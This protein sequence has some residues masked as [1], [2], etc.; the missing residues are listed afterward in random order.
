MLEYEVTAVFLAKYSQV[1]NS[2]SSSKTDQ[3]SPMA[4]VFPPDFPHLWS[5]GQGPLGALGVVGTNS[6]PC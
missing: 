6:C 2:V 1:C 5:S 4:L 3:A